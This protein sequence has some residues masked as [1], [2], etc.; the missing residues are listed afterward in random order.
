MALPSR[1]IRI[2]R[3]PLL[4][5]AHHLGQL[6]VD[7]EAERQALAGGLQLEHAAPSRARSRRSASARRSSVSLPPSMR[8]MSSVPSISDSRCSPPRRITLHGLLAVRRHAAS[9]LHQLRIAEDAVERRAQLVADGADVAALGLVGLLGARW[10]SAAAWPLQRFV[11][12]PVRVDLAHQQVRL[13]V[14]FLL[15]HLPAL[16]RQHQPPGDDAGDQ[17]QRHVGLEEARAQRPSDSAA[18]SSICASA[19][20]SW[21]YSRPNTAASSGT[22]TSI[23]SRKW[24]RPVSR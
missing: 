2:W 13:P 24:P 14:R 21:W 1:L 3:T 4:V 10:P 7:L 15:R 20:S 11:G 16:V 22:T 6:A 23:S 17:Q 12:L 5:G 19:R 8:A 18:L 9:S